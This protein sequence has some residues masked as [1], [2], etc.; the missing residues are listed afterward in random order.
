MTY[1]QLMNHI[2]CNMT[3]EQ[4]DMDV[5]VFAPGVEE[6]FGLLKDCPVVAA[7]GD[8]VLDDSHP[9]LVINN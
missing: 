1:R 7:D 6:Y 2:V 9:Y 3:E 8:D 4:K 5:T